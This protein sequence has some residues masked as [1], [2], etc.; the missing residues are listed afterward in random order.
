[1]I[2]DVVKLLDIMG[3]Y[4]D[5][6]PNKVQIRT[7]CPIHNGEG[8]P[9]CINLDRELYFCQSCKVGGSLTQFIADKY[10][11]K[12]REARDM[13]KKKGI[14]GKE[15]LD[16]D[17][18]VVEDLSP[19]PLFTESLPE[20][21]EIESRYRRISPSTMKHFGIYFCTK[22]FYTNSLI[23][24]VHN[25]HGQLVGYQ[26]RAIGTPISPRSK[27]MFEHVL[28]KKIV[29][30]YHRV[31]D[32]EIL[33]VLEG[34]ASVLNFYEHGYPNAVALLGS[35]WGEQ[36]ANIL[37]KHKLILCLDRDEAGDTARQL[38]RDTKDINVINEI[39][40]PLGIEYDEMGRKDF[41]KYIEGKT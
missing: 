13:M 28:A 3:I 32:Y 35:L 27:Y 25:E 11:I 23:I 2:T 10:H 1:M 39:V 41:K 6:I 21:I 19:H 31:K 18:K 29:Y 24:P 8:E 40:L 37:R 30:N 4:V 5:H 34:M 20:G 36:K 38:I 12:W 16:F 26:A 9:F 33:F 7:A 14:V 15:R 22:G 17:Y